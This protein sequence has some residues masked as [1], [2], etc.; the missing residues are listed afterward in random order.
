MGPLRS[1][2]NIGK[3]MERKLNSIGVFTPEELSNTGSKEVFSKL[4]SMYSNVCLV[5]LYMLQAAIDDTEMNQLSTKVKSE[6]KLYSD[7]IKK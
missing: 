6:L 5:H 1:M 7:S 2:R 4:K 3:E